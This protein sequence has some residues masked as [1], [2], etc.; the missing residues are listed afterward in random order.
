MYKF[1]KIKNQFDDGYQWFFKPSNHKQILEHFK[2]FCGREI[3]RG[4]KDKQVEHHAITP[5][6]VSVDTLQVCHAMLGKNEKWIET[7]INLEDETLKDRLKFFD[8]GHDMY[9]SS[10]LSYM[11]PNKNS[12]IQSR[13]EKII[14]KDDL[15]FPDDKLKLDNVRYISWPNGKHVY[16]KIGDLDII[17][18]HGNQKWGTHAEAE[19]AAKWF[20]KKENKNR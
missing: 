4:I 10:G 18:K 11:I 14:E 8:D 3:E 12:N 15:S 19:E 20:I 6:R 5:W 17:D 2:K 7:A 1:V 13:I 16:A 9:F